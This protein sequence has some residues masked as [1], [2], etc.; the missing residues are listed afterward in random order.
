MRLE[1]RMLPNKIHEVEPLHV[2]H[3]I[4]QSGVNCLHISQGNENI[5]HVISGGDDQALH[6]LSIELTLQQMN[7][8]N[9]VKREQTHN[10]AVCL[11]KPLLLISG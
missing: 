3:N 2:M 11:D 10:S 4:H 6:Y 5:F 1:E 8:E 9:M 7:D